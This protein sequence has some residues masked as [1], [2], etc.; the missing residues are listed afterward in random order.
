LSAIADGYSRSSNAL[1]GRHSARRIRSMASINFG[2]VTKRY[3]DGF[4]AVKDMNLAVADGEFMI[5]V[6][7]SGL[8]SQRRR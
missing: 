8:G 2:H 4:E 5:L 6:G 1:A 3:G 7:P